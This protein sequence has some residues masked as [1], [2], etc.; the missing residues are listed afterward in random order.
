MSWGYGEKKL[1]Q[2]E[3]LLHNIKEAWVMIEMTELSWSQQQAQ[4]PIQ[5]NK[6]NI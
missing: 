5:L 3:L 6:H 2:E 4:I 1:S